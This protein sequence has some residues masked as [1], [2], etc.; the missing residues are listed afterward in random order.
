MLTWNYRVFLE[1]DGDYIV[2]EVFYDETGEIIAC[3]QDAVEPLGESL[4]ALREDIAMFQEA[5]QLPVLTLA[6]VPV[7]ATFRE[8]SQ[9]SESDNRRLEDV[10]RELELEPTTVPNDHS[11]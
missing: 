8:R 7:S 10:L 1:D 2:R 5:L 9:H 11:K 6:D 4:Q 3:T